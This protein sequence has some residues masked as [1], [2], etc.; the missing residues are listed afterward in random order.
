MHLSIIDN[1]DT[2]PFHSTC[3]T[4]RRHSIVPIFAPRD[5]EALELRPRIP[6]DA[7][8]INVR[9]KTSHPTRRAHESVAEA[10]LDVLAFINIISSPRKTILEQGNLNIKAVDETLRCSVGRTAVV[11][12]LASCDSC[13]C[14]KMIQTHGL[15]VHASCSVRGEEGSAISFLYFT[16]SLQRQPIEL[17]MPV[18]KRGA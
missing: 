12:S 11:D 8:A 15:S 5:P 10:V 7:G 9:P 4:G 3:L 1:I 6:Y 2:Y 16:E 14:L 13:R 17:K 18:Q